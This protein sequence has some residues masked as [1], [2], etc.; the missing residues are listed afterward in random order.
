[1]VNSTPQT[2]NSSPHHGSGN[3]GGHQSSPDRSVG[4][5]AKHKHDD[6]R[7]GRS[8]NTATSSPAHPRTTNKGFQNSDSQSLPARFRSHAHSPQTAT[9][10]YKVPMKGAPE[11][12]KGIP[13]FNLSRNPHASS[14]ASTRK[15]SRPRGTAWL[16]NSNYFCKICDSAF[17]SID[18]DKSGFVDQKEL[19]SGLLLVHLKLGMYLGPAAC[20]PIGRERCQSIFEKVDTDHSGTLDKDE[21]RNVMI[22]L[23]GNVLLRVIVQWTATIFI[24]PVIAQHSVNWIYFVWGKACEMTSTKHDYNLLTNWI[25]VAL[26]AAYE[27]FLRCLPGY[28]LLLTAELDE[29]LQAVPSSVWNAFPLTLISSFLGIAV[30]PWVIFKI[31]D[32]FQWLASRSI[33]RK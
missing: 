6:T 27:L 7:I 13:R 32:F 16:C 21:F 8:T 24:V 31:D 33:S 30:V 1:M 12:G 4:S 22:F 19:Y 28:I 3:S 23:F 2:S 17:E 25:K 29:V 9:T 15:S 5:Q 26:T 11:A 20:K 18:V 10:S 14:D